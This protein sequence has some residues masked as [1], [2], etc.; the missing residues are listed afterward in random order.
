LSIS[1][2]GQHFVVSIAGFPFASIPLSLCFVEQQL[3]GHF[4]LELFSFSQAL[5]FS[6][7]LIFT[8]ALASA[9]TIANVDFSESSHA[10]AFSQANADFL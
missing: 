2:I 8:Q 1:S 6:Q 5:I 4:I 10:L 3:S 7:N 9:Q